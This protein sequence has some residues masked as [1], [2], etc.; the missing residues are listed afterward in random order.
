MLDKLTFDQFEKL[1]HTLP[2]LRVLCHL[3][4]HHFAENHLAKHYLAECHLAKHYL[5]EHHF[6][7]F[8]LAKHHLADECYCPNIFG[9]NVIRPNII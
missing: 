3:T 6:N 5:A 1:K 4:E 2:K 9:L 7:E 8:H